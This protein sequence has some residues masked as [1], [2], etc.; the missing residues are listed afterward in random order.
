M[1][2]SGSKSLINLTA[3]PFG[4]TAFLLGLQ[5]PLA[6]LR[7]VRQPS[8]HAPQ[9]RLLP[10]E[11]ALPLSWCRVRTSGLPA[12]LEAAWGPRKQQFCLCRCVT[13]M[14]TG[15]MPDN[16]S[17]FYLAGCKV[18]ITWTGRVAPGG[19]GR[20]PKRWRFTAQAQLQKTSPRHPLKGANTLFCQVSNFAKT[21]LFFKV[22]FNN[23]NS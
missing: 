12:S 21:T 1:Q 7:G 10:Q 15:L 13:L 5:I 20:A 8:V 23:P 6:H 2:R 17:N 22:H 19:P 9:T 14:M 11:R 4:G 3:C 18:R 16:V